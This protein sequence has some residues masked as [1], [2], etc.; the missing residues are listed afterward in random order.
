MLES[1]SRL[2][3]HMHHLTLPPKHQSCGGSDDENKCEAKLMVLLKD[4]LTLRVISGQEKWTSM[5]PYI[6]QH[7]GLTEY[8]C[9][10]IAL[11]IQIIIS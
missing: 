9:K 4:Y 10:E 7:Q 11:E 1:F 3:V 2:F 6:R 8:V 5:A